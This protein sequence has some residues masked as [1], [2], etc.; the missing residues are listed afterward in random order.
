MRNEHITD[1]FYHQK[2]NRFHINI[3]HSRGATHT[4]SPVVT[5]RHSAQP[6]S[7]LPWACVEWMSTEKNKIHVA[8]HIDLLQ[9]SSN[10]V[11]N[12]A[13]WTTSARWAWGTVLCPRADVLMSAVCE[14]AATRAGQSALTWER[15]TES[16]LVVATGEIRWHTLFVLHSHTI[17]S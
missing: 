14:P 10:M 12:R 17:S 15:T 13:D 11:P 4:N 7:L 9:K 5:E 3:Q 6:V 8:R 2:G 1:P 16:L